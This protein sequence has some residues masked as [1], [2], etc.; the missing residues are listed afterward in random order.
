MSKHIDLDIFGED[1]ISSFSTYSQKVGIYTMKNLQ[2]TWS[3][4]M[5][6]CLGKTTVYDFL[7][8]HSVPTMI[9]PTTDAELDSYFSLYPF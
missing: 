3:L 7:K 1:L 5:I 6:A 9:N 2:G 8:S 4:A